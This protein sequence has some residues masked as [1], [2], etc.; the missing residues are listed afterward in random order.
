[1]ERPGAQL[2][3]DPP[4]EA[5]MESLKEIVEARGLKKVFLGG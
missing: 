3:T 5:H 2:S 1:L 4:D